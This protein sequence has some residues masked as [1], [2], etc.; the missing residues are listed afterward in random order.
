MFKIDFNK[1]V[2][3]LLLTHKRGNVT[4]VFLL[5]ALKPVIDIYDAFIAFRYQKNLEATYN[6]QVLG[7]ETYLRNFF[8]T[9]DIFI[10]DSE[11]R[12]SVHVYNKQENIHEPYIY[13][14]DEELPAAD[15][16]W[17]FNTKEDEELS[18]NAIIQVPASFESSSFEAILKKA[19]NQ[20][21]FSDKTYIIQ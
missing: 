12:E 15:D 19:I 5:A 16:N 11:L 4:L 10:I 1:L 7:L 13:Q 21:I 9:D 3:L 17:F 18:Y 6:S 20:Y 14:K 8:G 2:F